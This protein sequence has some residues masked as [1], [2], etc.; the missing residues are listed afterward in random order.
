MYVH[1]RD[2]VCGVG[3]IVWPASGPCPWAHLVIHAD[4]LKLVKCYDPDLHAYA[5]NTQIY[6]FLPP[7]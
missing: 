3:G 1:A 4:L 6:G 7:V 2:R 5:D